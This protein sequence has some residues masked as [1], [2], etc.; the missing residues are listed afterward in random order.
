MTNGAGHGKR[1]WKRRAIK[2]VVFIALRQIAP[3]Q[4]NKAFASRLSEAGKGIHDDLR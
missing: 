3:C 2:L 4:K 1:R